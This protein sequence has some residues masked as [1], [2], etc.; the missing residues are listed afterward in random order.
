M[1][2]LS[3]S[4]SR[5]SV[6]KGIWEFHILGIVFRIEN[7]LDRQIVYYFFILVVCTGSCVCTLYIATQSVWLYDINVNT[8]C[9][10]LWIMW[11]YVH[12]KFGNISADIISWLHRFF[13]WSL[14]NRPFCTGMLNDEIA[15]AQIIHDVTHN[16]IDKTWEALSIL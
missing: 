7:H 2:M 10:Y 12:P 6:I 14:T 1:S 16:V 4:V 8:L 13:L 9:E 5:M 15:R 3:L 11:L